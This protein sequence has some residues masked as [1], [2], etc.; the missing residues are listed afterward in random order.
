[1]AAKKTPKRGR[2]PLPAAERSAGR[3]TVRLLPHAIEKLDALR[4]LLGVS[5]VEVL[6]I[7]LDELAARRLR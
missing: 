7:A 5:D 2:P 4:K 6:R 3:V 1:M